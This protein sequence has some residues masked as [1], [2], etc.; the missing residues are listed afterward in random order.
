ME[1]QESQ[2]VP[3]DALAVILGLPRTFLRREAERGAIP[4]VQ[5]G[6]F[7]RFDPE[8]VREHLRRRAE[9]QVRGGALEAPA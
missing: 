6:A 7:R 2:Y 3:L 5:A 9:R 8:Q 4:F 1:Q